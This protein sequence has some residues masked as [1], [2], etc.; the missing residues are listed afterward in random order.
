MSMTAPSTANKLDALRTA[1]KAKM[2]YWDASDE[3]EA[4]TTGGD[5]S[6]KQ[7]DAIHDH[8]ESLAAGFPRAEFDPAFITE[9]HLAELEAKLAEG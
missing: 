4:V 3:L 2:A 7:S 8:I 1:V 6:D 5:P 9:E